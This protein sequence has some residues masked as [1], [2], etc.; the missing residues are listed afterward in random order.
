MYFLWFMR[1]CAC[2]LNNV[3]GVYLVQVSCFLLVSRVGDIFSGNGPSHWL[4]DYANFT[5]LPDTNTGS[6]TLSAILYKHQ[7]NPLLSMSNYI[8]LVI[9]RN[10]SN[11]Q[12]SLSKQRKLALTAI[13][14]LSAL[15]CK[16]IGACKK[17]LNQLRPL[18]RPRSINFFHN[19]LN[20]F[21]KTV[22]LSTNQKK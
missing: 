2:W 21:H 13:N 20:L 3:S 18:V 7:A 15:Y 1:V 6:T 9:N 4:E 11:K 17:Y 19:F 8:P 16:I 14:K 12:L 5:P 22:P 10:D